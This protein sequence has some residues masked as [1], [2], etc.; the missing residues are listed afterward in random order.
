MGKRLRRTEGEAN[1]HPVHPLDSESNFT[2]NVSLT[3]PCS[4][5]NKKSNGNLQRGKR[6]PCVRR[7]LRRTHRP[8]RT[9]ARLCSSDLVST[10][11]VVQITMTQ[12]SLRSEA[13][14]HHKLHRLLR[15]FVQISFSSMDDTSPRTH[16]RPLQTAE[17]TTGSDPFPTIIQLFR[18]YLLIHECVGATE[19]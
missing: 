14:S 15:C 1:R 12:R 3:T 11:A 19:N 2:Q 8:L 17:T 7:W 10:D 5:L 16:H 13:P 4:D 18:S 6:N 9:R